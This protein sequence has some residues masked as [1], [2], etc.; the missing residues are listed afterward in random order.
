[1]GIPEIQPLT[2]ADTA[3]SK[4]LLADERQRRALTQHGTAPSIIFME[5]SPLQTRMAVWLFP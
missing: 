1:V 3:I 5:S 4:I 2:N